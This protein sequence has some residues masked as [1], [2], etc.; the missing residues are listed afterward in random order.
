MTSYNDAYW[1]GEPDLPDVAYDALDL[2]TEF[3]DIS[4]LKHELK[5][6]HKYPMLSLEKAY[7]LKE[8]K[9]FFNR[10]STNAFIIQPK[11]D[12]VGISCRYENGVFTKA[13]TR[14]N[15]L[16]GEDVT[17]KIQ[18]FVPENLTQCLSCEIR[19]ELYIRKKDFEQLSTYKSN[20]STVAGWCNS[21]NAMKLPISVIFFDVVLD[22][23]PWTLEEKSVWLQKNFGLGALTWEKVVCSSAGEL[24]T[25]LRNYYS[26]YLT[27]KIF[28]LDG[29]VVK[30]NAPDIRQKL[31][32]SKNYPRWALALKSNEDGIETIV[33]GISYTIGKTGKITPIA[34]LSPVEIK[35]ST[36]RRVT[37]NNC[38][39]LEK[40]DVRPGDSVLI[41]KA[42]EIIPQIV[43][44][45]KKKR[46]ADSVP[47]DIAKS[48]ANN[49]IATA[50]REGHWV[51]V[52]K[53]EQ[54]QKQI[55]HYAQT[56]KI[57]FL[58]PALIKKLVNEELVTSVFDLYKLTPEQLMLCENVGE[59]TSKKII[60]NIQ[61]TKK[62][63]FTDWL[64]ACGIPQIGPQHGKLISNVVNSLEEF[65]NLVEQIEELIAYKQ[66]IEEEQ[67]LKQLR[68]HKYLNRK[69]RAASQLE[70]YQMLLSYINQQT[71]EIDYIKQR[72]R[73]AYCCLFL[74]GLRIS[75]IRF[76]TVSQILTLL[77]HGYIAI[78]R[79]KRGPANKKAFLNDAGKAI[80]QERSQDIYNL[81]H[82]QGIHLYNQQNNSFNSEYEHLFLFSSIQSQGQKPLSRTFFTHRINTILKSIPEF[83]EQHFTSHSF[84]K[85]YITKLWKDYQDIEFVRQVIGHIYIGTTSRYISQLSDDEIQT[86]IQKSL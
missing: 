43:K 19:G 58:G 27:N 55:L 59:K 9:R 41:V 21:K 30:V 72:L 62:C 14:G 50:Y 29:V 13:T 37:L 12:G 3:E 52:D 20:R 71:K 57:G 61:V 54:L 16:E 49:N 40:M 47:F 53:K 5:N 1:K 32:A 2:G 6:K 33:E 25:K 77:K 76:I 69:K 18:G 23:D 36:I 86:K 31:G 56:L 15:S 11:I 51:C 45:K 7:C 26:E 83:Q 75:E 60:N 8:I 46:A 84:R 42:G 24:E 70:H 78:D 65:V 39:Y 81:L 22:N 66:N 64:V 4:R 67:K 73:V 28:P 17:H 85:G 82:S 68:R 44:V 63:A 35:G 80:L 79:S 48:L 38:D 34:Q 10:V 74:T